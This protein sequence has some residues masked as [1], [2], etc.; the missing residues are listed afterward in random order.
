VWNR[1]KWER[2]GVTVPFT[3]AGDY[4]NVLEGR[5]SVARAAR[6]LFWAAVAAVIKKNTSLRT[7]SP[8]E[9]LRFGSVSP[10]AGVTDAALK[11]EGR[12][13]LRGSGGEDDD[14]RGERQSW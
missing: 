11:G 6:L 9:W 7:Q 3:I 12:C 14:A 8:K 1:R 13:L 4:Q 5:E 2:I 10:S